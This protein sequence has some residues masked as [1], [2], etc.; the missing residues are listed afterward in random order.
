MLLDAG[1][2]M[3]GVALK[4]AMRKDLSFIANALNSTLMLGAIPAFARHMS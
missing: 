3:R 1:S 4:S 2:T